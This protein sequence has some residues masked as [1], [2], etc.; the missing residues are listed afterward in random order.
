[1]RCLLTPNTI[2]LLEDPVNYVRH[3]PGYPTGEILHAS[4]A[5]DV[6]KICL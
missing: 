5:I 4:A 2:L 6:S 3:V 1:M